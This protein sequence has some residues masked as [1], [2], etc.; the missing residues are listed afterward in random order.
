MI[1]VLGEIELPEILYKYRDWNSKYHRQLIEKQIAYFASPGTFNDP[2][3]CKIPIRY[4]INSEQH[5]EDIYSDIIKATPENVSE[6]KIRELSKRWV[7]KGPISPDSFKKNDQ[8]Y[9]ND[10]NKRMGV[11]SISEKNNDILMWGHYSN[12]HTGF[13][14]GFDTA[15]LLKTEGVDYIGKVEY[16]QEFP[17]I[18][19]DR[20]LE[21]Q[22]KKQIFSKWN[23]WQYEN[24]FRLTKNHIKNRKIKIPKTAFKEVI[25]GFQMPE[26]QRAK[27][28]K[29][30][31]RNFPEILIYEALPNEEKFNIEIKEIE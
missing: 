30:V 28:I 20:N 19:P 10:L 11:F 22:F 31:R 29:L 3:D 5:L 12:S 1:K 26:K 2:F 23:K 15:E 13:C 24:E 16:F 8:E 4:D 18:I 21:S 7:Q 27:L 17:V 9:F 14:V 6:K 25:L